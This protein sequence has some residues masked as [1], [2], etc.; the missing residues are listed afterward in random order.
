MLD[1]IGP[2]L[3]VSN[4]TGKPIELKADDHV[5]ITSDTTIQPSADILPVSYADLARVRPLYLVKFI[6]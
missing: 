1:T 6:F 2:E 3:Q 4:E 5:T